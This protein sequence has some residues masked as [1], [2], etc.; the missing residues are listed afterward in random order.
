MT[1]N[2]S[3]ANI[4][5]AASA[6]SVLVNSVA[7]TVNT[8][9]ISGTKVQL[10]LATPVVNGNVV[11]V[12]YTKPTVNPLQTAS[13]GTAASISAQTVTNGVTAAVPVYVSSA[14][15]SATPALLEMT[16][17][18]SLA[19]IVPAAS[20]FSV[21]VNSVARTVNTVAISGTKVQLTLA[22]PVVNGNVVTVSYTK[23]TVNPLQTASAGT[24]ASISAQTVTNGVTAVVPVYVS[25]AIASATPA[26][27][28]MTYN[29]SLANIV[30][31]ASAFSVMVN[32]VARTIN[33]VAISGTKVQLTLATPVVNGNVVTVSYTKPTVNPLQTASAGTAASISAQTVTNGVTAT[34]PVYVSSSIGSATPALLEMTYNTSLANIVPAVSAFSV[35]G[36]FSCTDNKYGCYLRVKST[37]DPCK[38]CH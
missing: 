27:L 28:E 26:L 3:L 32:S 20:A 4:V 15:A 13:A 18:T 34:I 8:V 38:P 21:M 2:T 6:F 35:H 7:R 29:T 37:A 1:Y 17:N 16:Y 31:A 22:T 24:A 23:P 19:N 12:S 11:T 33:T 30:P 25:S 5:P 36:E 9:A 10:T 14:I